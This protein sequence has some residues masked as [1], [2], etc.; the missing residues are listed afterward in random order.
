MSDLLAVAQRAG[1]VRADVT[2]AVVHLAGGGDLHCLRP[3]EPGARCR[4][5]SSPSCA[6]DSGHRPKALA[7]PSG[8]AGCCSKGNHVNAAVYYETGNPDVFRYEHVPDPT[9]GPTEILVRVEA[10]SIEGG[11]TLNRLGGAMN[12]VPHVV[13]YQCA[14]VVMS[15]GEDVAGFVVG[16]RVVTVGIDGSHAELRAVPEPFAWKIP[17]P[18]ATDEAACVPVPWGTADDCLFEFGHLGRGRDGPDPRWGQRRRPGRDSA[19]E[20]GGRPGVR[21]RI[22]RRQAGT[23]Q[24]ARPRR[25]DQLRQG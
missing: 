19:G 7:E 5:N 14:G 25:G 9:P 11:D 23:A 18:L 22:E 24:R 13:G 20:T 17:D 21:H 15:V 8:L 3:P 4:V 2:S 1:A 10:I 16:D 6:T 12:A